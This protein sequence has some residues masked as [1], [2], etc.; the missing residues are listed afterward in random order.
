M[1][2]LVSPLSGNADKT[3]FKL[4]T[5]VPPEM[6]ISSNR[7]YYYRLKDKTQLYN[8]D[9]VNFENNIATVDHTFSSSFIK[10]NQ[11]DVGGYPL[12]I[13]FI[14][15]LTDSSSFEWFSLNTISLFSE[16]TFLDKDSVVQQVVTTLANI[17][18]NMTTDE[19]ISSANLI[20]TLGASD[21]SFGTLNN[22]TLSNKTEY[23]TKL[24]F[25]NDGSVN[26]L[27][28]VE[29]NNQYCN[30]QGTCSYA[31]EYKVIPICTCFGNYSGTFCELK[32][33]NQVLLKNYTLNI[34]LAITT[35]L[36]T[37]TTST[38]GTTTTTGTT[39]T[40]TSTAN[41]IVVTPI[42][43]NTVSSQLE[44]GI[45]VVD[46]IKDIT[47][48]SNVVNIIL[49][50]KSETT[51]QNV[52]NSSSSVINMIK[53]L[54]LFSNIQVMKTKSLTT[55]ASSASK[56]TTTGS[57]SN[58]RIL[59]ALKY[60]QTSSTTGSTD[61]TT[62]SSTNAAA[63]TNVPLTA[64][65]IYLNNKEL[66]LNNENAKSLIFKFLKNYISYFNIQYN[67]DLNSN[68]TIANTTDY[69]RSVNVSQYSIDQSNSN[70]D[71]LFG[72][73]LDSKTFDF[74]SFFSNRIRNKLSYIEAKD[75]V[76]N[77]LQSFNFISTERT[78]NKII[79]NVAFIAYINF[80]NPMYII[81][82]SLL[83]K[84]I[85]Q[86][87]F[88]VLYDINGNE[89]NIDNC[90]YEILH[91]FPL[92]PR[93]N[94]FVERY[95]V[96]PTRY[97]IDPTNNITSISQKYS[98][99]YMPIYIFPNGT[100]DKTDNSTKQ[101]EKYYLTYRFN[102]TEYNIKNLTIY[103][104]PL[105][106]A[107][108]FDNTNQKNQVK[109]INNGYVV[110]SSRNLA[111]FTVMTTY[112][113]PT[114]VED[115]YYFLRNG[116]IFL[117]GENWKTNSCFY[118]LVILLGINYFFVILL[119]I[120]GCC[121][122][123]VSKADNSPYDLYLLKL[124][125]QNFVDDNRRFD[126]NF[127]R[128]NLYEYLQLADRFEK[129]T[130]VEMAVDIPKKTNSEPGKNINQ[131]NNVETNKEYVNAIINENQVVLNIESSQAIPQTEA[132]YE[133]NNKTTV[134]KEV[135][136][137]DISPSSCNMFFF[138][139]ARNLYA[140]PWV[141]YSPFSPK[142]KIMAKV[143]CLVY[144]LIF[145]STLLFIWS[146]VKLSNQVYTDYKSLVY[147]VFVSALVSNAIFSLLNLLYSVFINNNRI[148]ESIKHSL[149]EESM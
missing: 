28:S 31:D 90:P 72:P 39:G 47:V 37:N 87:H 22:N 91:Y 128:L 75:C 144:L 135:K 129:K 106:I 2:L 46:N 51:V 77:Y 115:K 30:N 18:S 120:L 132:A 89:L 45:K 9:N 74:N 133:K 104:Q 134:E 42:I 38:N 92:F 3:V 146:S 21:A 8:I 97:N 36:L 103:N 48:F 41:T 94:T 43:L 109:Y 23:D 16:T 59:K 102:L 114:Q 127:L 58:N 136:K 108:M 10:T 64:E 66:I 139:F 113:P 12:I 130:A 147:I 81:D 7:K 141:I 110:G 117:D 111:E 79:N 116:K 93:N 6:A 62:A 33:E 1:N 52:V 14:F 143:F 60:L 63:N 100:I 124:E 118:V 54:F 20:S 123:K 105:N 65:E 70:F 82:N 55:K 98:T 71:L 140:A 25:N 80:K 56:K 112:D 24:S 57:T 32:N 4:S 44:Q 68:N 11:L 67:K 83:D 138:I 96:N 84:S 149:S 13:E 34:M 61:A 19:L 148:I 145:F 78:P 15:G 50:S 85:S 95:N 5:Y 122:P 101:L 40:S 69:L 53:N 17:T 142:W 107:K 119:M 86:S 29:C 35:K 131:Y 125:Y 88:M 76:S 73:I 126:N 26:I 49:D 121:N 137:N 27:K 99:S